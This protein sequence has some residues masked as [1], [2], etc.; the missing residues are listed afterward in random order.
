MK[1]IIILFLFFSTVDKQN[2]YVKLENFQKY[3]K[4][5]M[6]KYENNKGKIVTKEVK[7]RPKGYYGFFVH[8]KIFYLF[9]V[10]Y[11]RGGKVRYNV[12]GKDGIDF[13]R[14]IGGGRTVY[15]QK[16]DC[17]MHLRGVFKT[18]HLGV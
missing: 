5:V 15:Y 4:Y 6:V 12:S 8:D 16:V 13:M 10:S 17:E 11:H 14:K 7:I 2:Y 3:T 18:V 1:L 9:S